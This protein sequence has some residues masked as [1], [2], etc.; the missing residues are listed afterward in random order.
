[1]KKSLLLGL[2]SCLLILPAIA[3]FNDVSPG[4]EITSALFNKIQQTLNGIL[5]IQIPTGENVYS[6]S[7]DSNGTLLSQNVDWID[8]NASGRINTGDFLVVY[9]SGTFTVTPVLNITP[10]HVDNIAHVSAEYNASS[11]NGVRV[12]IRALPSTAGFRDAYF[13][14]T[15]HAQGADYKPYK[16]IRQIL[17]DAGLTF[18]SP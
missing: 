6:A 4:D 3:N 14:F 11:N 18:L 5:D 8:T 9:K 15:A 10:D 1:M 12:F 7:F 13:N 17:I 16:T 2:L